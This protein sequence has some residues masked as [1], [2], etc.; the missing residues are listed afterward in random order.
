MS[1]RKHGYSYDF[2]ISYAE[3]D[4]EWVDSYLVPALTAAEKTVITYKKALKPGHP[5]ISSYEEAVILSKK[6][7][8]VVTPE[9]QLKI[10]DKDF[11]YRKIIELMKQHHGSVQKNWPVV[12]LIFKDTPL[13]LRLDFLISLDFTNDHLWEK[14]VKRLLDSNNDFTEEVFE[15]PSSPYPGLASFEESQ[16]KY[17]YG[18]ERVIEELMLRRSTK[19]FTTILGSSG[20]GKSS[21][22]KAG[23]IPRTKQQD[24]DKTCRVH[25]VTPGDKPL[26]NLSKLFEDQ[27]F[28][29][30]RENV[31]GFIQEKAYSRLLVFIDQFEEVFTLSDTNH[32]HFYKAVGQLI[33]TKNCEVIISCRS[34]FYNSLTETLLWKYINGNIYTL[35]GLSEEE[36]KEAIVRPAR[37]V[38]VSI[39]QILVERMVNDAGT[40]SSILP[41][42]QATMNLLWQKLK[43]RYLPLSSYNELQI[44]DSRGKPIKGIK[45]AIALRAQAA[46]DGLEEHELSTAR[47]VLLRLVNIGE[48]GLPNTKQPQ[49]I[50]SLQICGKNTQCLIQ[51]LA[52][53]EHRILKTYNDNKVNKVSISH[54][55]IID[56]WPK[57]LEW[58]DKYRDAIKQRN[59]F[60]FKLN[61]WVRL[62]KK[63]A[64][65]LSK[66]E[67][68]EAEK[69]LTEGYH[70]TLGI[71][72]IFS[73]Y[74]NKSKNFINP[75]YSRSGL[76]LLATFIAN[77]SLLFGYFY[78]INREI[79]FL[80]FLIISIYL[81]TGIYIYQLIKKS[82]KDYQVQK[83]S[84]ELSASKFFIISS[85]LLFLLDITL[86][87]SEISSN[88]IIEK[89][90]KSKYKF[91]SNYNLAIYSETQ[92]SYLEGLDEILEKNN[93]INHFFIKNYDDLNKCQDYF[94]HTFILKK[95]I[96][97]NNKAEIIKHGILKSNKYKNSKNIKYIVK[98][99]NYE[100]CSSMSGLG[101]LLIENITQNSLKIVRNSG[102]RPS[103]S[104]LI[105]E[106]FKEGMSYYK[107]GDLNRAEEI[108]RD[109]VDQDSNFST[110]Y[111][112][113]G[114]ILL[115]KMK[116]K[117]A[118]IFLKSAEDNQKTNSSFFSMGIATACLRNNQTSCA[119]TYF[120]K[121]IQYKLSEPA[122]RPMIYNGLSV[123]Y[124]IEDNLR[125]SQKN[126]SIA[127]ELNSQLQDK[128]EKDYNESILVKNQ[129]ILDYKSK[130]FK[131][132][133]SNFKK[134]NN[135][136]YKKEKYYYLSK[137]YE[138]IGNK[139]ASC[140]FSKKFKSLGNN[141]YF[142]PHEANEP[143]LIC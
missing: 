114:D 53:K 59:K 43:I 101:I 112:M 121:A 1:T 110:A 28:K 35:L 29:F 118:V 127:F 80:N 44:S 31:K 6:V 27:D 83:I 87:F 111:Y 82:S 26:E 55:S 19:S 22:V 20:C 84:R 137:I 93:I 12:P 131:E 133:I 75:G 77:T 7:L 49:E 128:K 60:E 103:N 139:E 130:K 92:D 41:F 4:E 40:D 39:D 24:R 48:K 123:A 17:F 98:K 3:A 42:I 109:V 116:Y 5:K 97:I 119:K 95:Q 81:S 73:D 68:K 54:D 66:P 86:I 140:F 88:I 104:C 71:R 16:S 38:G 25:I 125:E 8:L 108:L 21:L 134:S 136:F 15:I 47:C 74:I 32:Q 94:S 124:R 115:K 117:E 11:G 107:N 141:F 72:E 65:L 52:S 45:A 50:E 37:K 61:E 10:D 56:G 120:E 13:P 14:Q 102:L 143:L 132:S 9:Y 30:N 23:L 79:S 138:K 99:T 106:K 63:D 96:S 62:G 70:E 18:R 33:D 142:N 46:L 67:L 78:F 89:Y 64:G 113:I 91:G 36:L 122:L 58:I 129:A 105:F 85:I 51:K 100:E 76:F 90:C 135:N 34:E 2:F 126:L 69:W 57:L